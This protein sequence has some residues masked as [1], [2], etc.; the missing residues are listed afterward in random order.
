MIGRKQVMQKAVGWA[1]DSGMIG[2]MASILAETERAQTEAVNDLAAAVGAE[3]ATLEPVDKSNRVDELLEL[4][5]GVTPG[6]GGS[7]EEW[8][9]RHVVALDADAERITPYVG[10]GQDEWTDQVAKWAGAYRADGDYPDMTDRDLAAHHVRSAFDAPGLD[11][12]EAEVVDVDTSDIVRVATVGRLTDVEESI[13]IAAD[14]AE[15]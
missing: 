10:M 11:W 2:H 7:A 9:A 6:G 5:E 13:R 12:F 15:S 14:A 1:M 8:Y 3:G 4:I